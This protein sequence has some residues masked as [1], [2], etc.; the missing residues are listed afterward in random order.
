MNTIKDGF[1]S[2][3]IMRLQTKAR[4]RK[5]IELLSIK[6]HSTSSICFIPIP[7]LFSLKSDFNGLSVFA[8]LPWEEND[9]F[10]SN[11][12][13]HEP[14]EVFCEFFQD[15]TAGPEQH[16]GKY[17]SKEVMGHLRIQEALE[18]YHNIEIQE[19]VP[20]HPFEITSEVTTGVSMPSSETNIVSPVAETTKEFKCR[21][22][23]NSYSKRH[24][25]IVHVRR[26][27]KEAK[28]QY[29]FEFG[30]YCFM[31]NFKSSSSKTIF[32]ERQR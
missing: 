23:S 28:F 8:N 9:E 22:C 24:N 29:K 12:F 32:P 15:T 30:E 4:S 19:S 26:H 20:Q 2:P 13:I 3:F 10:Q 14:V 25:P 11:I 17:V 18:D 27:S 1:R 7:S 21:I 31:E 5:S 16:N 6:M